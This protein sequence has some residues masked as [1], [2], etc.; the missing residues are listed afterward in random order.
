M[1]TMTRLWIGWSEIQISV[2]ARAFFLLQK[3]Q[4]GSGAHTDPYSMGKKVLTQG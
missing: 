4:T 1:F 2:W 3:F